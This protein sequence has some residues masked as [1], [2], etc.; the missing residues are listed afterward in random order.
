MIL[1]INIFLSFILIPIGN[2]YPPELAFVIDESSLLL[3]AKGYKVGNSCPFFRIQDSYSVACRIILKAAFSP[4][5][6]RINP[7]DFYSINSPKSRVVLQSKGQCHHLVCVYA[8]APG[9]AESIPAGKFRRICKL[10]CQQKRVPLL[11]QFRSA[12]QAFKPYHE[13]EHPGHDKKQ[14]N[15]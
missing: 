2:N 4:C 8:V 1:S 11:Q 9:C 7:P 6:C 15:S 13:D 5:S 10:G 12:T 3:P 14:G